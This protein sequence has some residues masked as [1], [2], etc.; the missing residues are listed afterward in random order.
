MGFRFWIGLFLVLCIGCSTGYP[1]GG[2]HDKD[3]YIT[4][5][6]FQNY[7]DDEAFFRCEDDKRKQE[8]KLDD[9][10]DQ[11]NRQQKMIDFIDKVLPEL[12]KIKADQ[13]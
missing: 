8:S 9:L 10:N 2:F 3:A 4:W 11:I 6:E 13:K 1:N 7:K 5:L 12:K